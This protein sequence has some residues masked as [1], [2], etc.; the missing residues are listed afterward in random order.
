LNDRRSRGELPTF[1]ARTGCWWQADAAG[2]E[3]SHVMQAG[4]VNWQE[5]D[6]MSRACLLAPP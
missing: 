6:I 5:P 3:F 4:P 1:G 2:V